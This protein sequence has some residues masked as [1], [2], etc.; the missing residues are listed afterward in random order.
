MPDAG[1]ADLPAYPLAAPSRAAG[2]AAAI[3]ATDGQPRRASRSRDDVG[4]DHH[5][6]RHQLGFLGSGAGSAE[7]V[8]RVARIRTI[9]PAFFRHEELYDAEIATGLP[10]R[11]AFAGLWT[12]ADRE[13]R[14]E[15]KPRELKLDCLPFDKVDFSAVLDALTTHGFIV[16][17]EANGKTYGCI[18]SWAS[19]QVINHREAPSAIPPPPDG[20][21]TLPGIDMGTPGHARGEQEGNGR[22][23][24]GNS[25]HTALRAR[26][27]R[28]WQ[29]YPRK[30]AKDAAWRE[31]LRRS[32]S[33]DLTEQMITAVQSQRASEQWRKEGGQFIPHPRTWLHQGRWQDEA[34]R[35]LRAEAAE[36][37]RE[38]QQWLQQQRD[39]RR[40]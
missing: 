34:V 19:H 31:W 30:T 32:P 8:V 1:E 11:V 4:I 24:E 28:F 18:P 22:E 39:A 2:V 10:L 23:Q 16:R 17:Y 25:T 26:F 3:H 33:D 35:D 9:K 20:M 14:F 36:D 21:I 38:Y 6:R 12:T 27:E 5:S 13:G 15:W 40:V 37:G 29:A 7:G